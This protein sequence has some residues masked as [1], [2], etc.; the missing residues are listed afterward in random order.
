M[1]F[2]LLFSTLLLLFGSCKKSEDPSN[3]PTLEQILT[4]G[5]WR[6]SLFTESGTDK[7]SA[8]NDN[9]LQ[10][11]AGG[12]LRVVKNSTSFTGNWII[13]SGTQ[14]VTLNISSFDLALLALNTDYRLTSATDTNVQLRDDGSQKVLHLQRL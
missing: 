8:Y 4:Q 5:T 10:F 7:T 12:V 1:K 13:N 3:G 11:Q 2:T 14:T 9:T 6:V